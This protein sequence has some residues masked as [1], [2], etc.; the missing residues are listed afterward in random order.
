MAVEVF[1][2][3]TKL[4][5][6]V[7]VECTAR[8]HSLVLDEPKE[9]GGTDT[10]MN[11]LEA[12]LCALGACK[13]IVARLFAKAHEIDLQDFKVDLEGDLDMDGVMGKNKD[14]KIGFLEIRSKVY[15]KSGSPKDKVE[16][17]VRFIDKTCPVAASLADSP[18]MVTEL[19][20]E[21]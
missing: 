9:L 7:K 17:F 13:C 10:G 5:E 15:I 12:A 16:E 4:T 8:N 20:I 2:S 14:A 19:T 21:E 6:G 18:K 11:P 1:K 3:T